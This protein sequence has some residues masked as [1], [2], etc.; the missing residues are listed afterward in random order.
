MPTKR[1]QVIARTLELIERTDELVDILTRYKK[2]NMALI[3][4]LKD[5]GEI[6]D[7]LDGLGGPMRRR[8]LTEALDAFEAA[9]HAIRVAMFAL[10]GEQ[11]STLSELGRKLGISRQLASR[12]AAEAAATNG[13]R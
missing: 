2:A 3:D 9:R 6:V 1:K 11:G 8:E 13:R 4:L 12:L 10:A 5:G 7:A